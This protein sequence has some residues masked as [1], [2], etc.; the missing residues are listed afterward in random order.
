M[1]KT[2]EYLQAGTR[3]VWIIDP[4]SEIVTVYRS[5]SDIQVLSKRDEL[6]GEYVIPGFRCPLD[7][8]FV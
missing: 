6:D 7:K 3:L 2:I 8:I 4:K 5:L 1:E